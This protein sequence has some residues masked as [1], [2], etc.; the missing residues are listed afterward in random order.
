M[1][2]W[3]DA[4]GSGRTSP[5]A[6]AGSRRMTRSRS[7]ACSRRRRTL[8]DRVA[9]RQ[10]APRPDGRTGRAGARHAGGARARAARGRPAHRRRAGG[11]ARGPGPPR[12]RPRRLV[13]R[14]RGGGPGRRRGRRARRRRRG[15]HRR[16]KRA[17]AAGRCAEWR[18]SA[19]PARRAQPGCPCEPR[20]RSLHLQNRAAWRRLASASSCQQASAESVRLNLYNAKDRCVLHARGRPRPAGCEAALR[21]QPP[22]STCWRLRSAP[23]RRRPPATATAARRPPAVTPR[24]ARRRA[25]RARAGRCP[26]SR[27][28]R[29]QGSPSWTAA[30]RR[31]RVPVA[32]N[33][34]AVGGLSALGPKG[35]S[36]L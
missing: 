8:H 36:F 23:W 18:C 11:R 19:V 26:A 3:R 35:A 28:A 12:A 7:S 30:R 5:G 22:G 15:R 13:R 20:P 4:R 34:S 6:R 21:A 25:G 1:R 24:Q 27:P 14:G 16:P 9:A 17:R 32:Q 2:R 10:R 33:L 29:A 31:A